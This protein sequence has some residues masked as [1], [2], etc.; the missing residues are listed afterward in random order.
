MTNFD[1]WTFGPIQLFVNKRK[2]V[3]SDDLRLLVAGVGFE[4]H[5]LQVMSLT[6][7]QTA[8]PRDKK[9]VVII[10][11]KICLSIP[12]LIFFRTYPKIEN[13]NNECS[14]YLD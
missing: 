2:V 10:P 3:I 7:Y 14:Y 5:D 11:S 8:P 9:D 4:P 13:K 12:F 1:S 6:S